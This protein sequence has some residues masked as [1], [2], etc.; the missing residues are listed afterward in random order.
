[1]KNINLLIQSFLLV[2]GFFLILLSLFSPT[3]IGY[4][5][6]YM[7]LLGLTQVLFSLIFAIFSEKRWYFIFHLILSALVLTS[8]GYF[9]MFGGG[10]L[11]IYYW[12]LTYTVVKPESKS[13]HSTRAILDNSIQ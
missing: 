6:V 11:A 12:I 10:L 8:L 3:F 2:I 7:A 1:M 5:L 13:S 9:I 4:L